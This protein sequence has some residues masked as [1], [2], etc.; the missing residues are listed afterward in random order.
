[1]RFGRRPKQ[2]LYQRVRVGA[3]VEAERDGSPAQAV[4]GR[5]EV[6]ADV[7]IHS[8]SVPAGEATIVVR[9]GVKPRRDKTGEEEVTVVPSSPVTPDTV[10][11]AS[12]AVPG[13]TPF[14]RYR[15]VS[16]MV[17]IV[18]VCGSRTIIPFLATNLKLLAIVAEKHGALDK[19]HCRLSSSRASR[20]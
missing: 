11:S 12:E 6:D 20:H 19:G 5:E 1:V 13:E 2:A 4:N 10:K 16:L 3:E 17:W 18:A 7:R 15:V 8:A 9:D 14:E